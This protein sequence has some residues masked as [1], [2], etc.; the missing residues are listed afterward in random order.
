VGLLSLDMIKRIKIKELP[1]D[2]TNDMQNLAEARL[3]I[4]FGST[5][6]SVA[7]W[8]DRDNEVKGMTLEKQ[9]NFSSCI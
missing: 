8:S 6:S 2:K 9:K 4:D 7:Y 5:N 1:K 3:G